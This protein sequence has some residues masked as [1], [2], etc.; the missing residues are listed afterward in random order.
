MMNAQW[1]FA[2]IADIIDTAVLI[3]AWQNFVDC[4]GGRGFATWHRQTLW[5]EVVTWETNLT[6]CLFL[7]HFSNLTWP[8]SPRSS[9][10]CLAVRNIH[11]SVS[12]WIG[13]AHVTHIMKFVYFSLLISIVLIP[14]IEYHYQSFRGKRIHLTYVY[15]GK[16]SYWIISFS[17]MYK[18][19]K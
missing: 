13:T 3:L 7:S 9:F 12:Q 10:F 6:V 5:Q 2:D 14:L 4:T 16:N 18:I 19:Q 15:L 11:S 1:Q 8:L 17:N